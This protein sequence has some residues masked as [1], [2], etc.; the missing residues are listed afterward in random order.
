MSFVLSMNPAHTSLNMRREIERLLNDVS[1]VRTAPVFTPAANGFEDANGFR[2]EFEVPGFTSD[3][4]EVTAHDGALIVRGDKPAVK[5]PEGTRTLFAER[6]SGSFERKMR[7]PKTAD[8]ASI[9]ASHSNGVLSVYVAKLATVAPRKV[10]INTDVSST[11]TTPA[12]SESPT[13]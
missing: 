11:S 6:T 12:A 5:N 7:L 3:Q 10:T 9:S 13:A 8:V 2:M 4:L 1:P